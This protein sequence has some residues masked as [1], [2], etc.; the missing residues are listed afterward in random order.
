MKNCMNL[1]FLSAAYFL[2]A[3]SQSYFRPTLRERARAVRFK[4]AKFK[5]ALICL[6]DGWL[7]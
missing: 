3:F 6:L 2:V 4:R 7:K 5:S 1:T